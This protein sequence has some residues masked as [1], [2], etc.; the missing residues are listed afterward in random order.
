M[1]I[2]HNKF[3]CKQIDVKKPPPPKKKKDVFN[4]KK[5]IEPFHT[6][7]QISHPPPPLP[8]PQKH[9]AWSTPG[10]Y[11]KKKLKYEQMPFL[12]SSIIICLPVIYI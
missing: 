7:V 10:K 3:C 6:K 11:D 9:F 12:I 1:I 5:K 2:V 4:R 8:H